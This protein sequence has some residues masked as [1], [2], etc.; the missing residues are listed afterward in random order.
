M[1]RLKGF[2]KGEFAI[3]CETEKEAIELMNI[4]AE[5][6]VTWCDGEKLKNTYFIDYKNFT[7]YYMDLFGLKYW[8]I[9]KI[10]AFAKI[11]KF[12]D[13]KENKMNSSKGDKNMTKKVKVKIK[14]LEEL[15]DTENVIV[16]NGDIY[17]RGC[18]GTLI[19]MFTKDMRKFCSKQYEI[20][21]ETTSGK[22]YLQNKYIAKW[23]CSE[24]K[25]ID[26]RKDRFNELKEGFTLKGTN[27]DKRIKIIPNQKDLKYFDKQD[28]NLLLEIM[29]ADCSTSISLNFDQWDKL[30]NYVNKLKKLKNK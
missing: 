26:E 16:E 24:W 21:E 5:N 1:K 30:N 9:N 10:G 25:E 12:K 4:L 19:K 23:M 28:N 3:N 8:D 13:L 17:Y 29:F 2:L 15:L 27:Y 7:C 11:I 18:F 14:T 22:Y 6:N 20:E